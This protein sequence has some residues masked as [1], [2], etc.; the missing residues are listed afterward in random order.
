[1]IDFE[2]DFRFM[3]HGIDELKLEETADENTYKSL[4]SKSTGIFVG[5][6]ARANPE[7]H[8]G[9]IAPIAPQDHSGPCRLRRG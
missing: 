4:F 1:M 6:R 2:T 8:Y 5:L 7:C 9:K 3:Q